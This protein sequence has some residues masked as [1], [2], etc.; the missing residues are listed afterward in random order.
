MP[1]K[2]AT[3]PF[4]SYADRRRAENDSSVSDLV[5]SDIFFEIS[6]FLVRLG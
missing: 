5:F 6:G 4:A 2:W 1:V 3:R